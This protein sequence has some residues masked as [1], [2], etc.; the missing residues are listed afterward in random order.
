MQSHDIRQLFL[1]FFAS[2][3]HHI[4][5]SASLIPENDPT[6]LF[7][8]AGMHPLVPYLMG[9][10]HP[11]GKRLVDVQKCI[12]TQ[13]IDDVGD[14]RHTT[15]FE[16]LGIWSLGDYFKTDIIPWTF[17]FF[18]TALEFDPARLYVTVFAGDDALRIPADTESIELWKNKFSTVGITATVAPFDNP[19]I[20]QGHRIY[21]YGKSKNWWG[22]AGLTGPCGPDTEV[23]YDT[24]RAHDQ[25]FGLV[26]HPNCDC[27]RFVEI[28]NDVFMEFN[29][30]VDA[31]Y[32][33]LAQKN[34]DVGWGLERLTAMTEHKTSIFETDL[35]APAITSAA[36]R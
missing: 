2:R 1:Q 7:T 8:T 34:V 17:E 18:T 5:P 27:G 13:D 14:H 11:E 33:P 24:G 30:T 23:F 35:F 25:K 15:F 21:R 20:A 10:A 12:R 22:P 3:G 4:I 26:C 28:G 9:E 32:V 6:V 19:D 31:A 16:M 36:G 29:K